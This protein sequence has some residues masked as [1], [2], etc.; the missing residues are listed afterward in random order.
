MS[1]TLIISFVFIY[2]HFFLIHQHLLHNLLFLVRGY[3]SPIYLSED[4]N[5]SVVIILLFAG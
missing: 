4:L 1:I 5:D 2:S 3:N